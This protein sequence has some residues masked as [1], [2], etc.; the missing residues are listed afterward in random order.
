MGLT[1]KG[2]IDWFGIKLKYTDKPKGYFYLPKKLIDV[3]I[4]NVKPTLWQRLQ[5]WNKGFK[6]IKTQEPR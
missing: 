6:W 5:M 4:S 2:G 1:V 3:T